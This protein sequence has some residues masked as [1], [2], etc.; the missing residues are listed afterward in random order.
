MGVPSTINNKPVN[1]GPTVRVT[2]GKATTEVPVGGPNAAANGLLRSQ[3]ANVREA[4]QI[5]PVAGSA[6]IR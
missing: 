2:R 5:A 3:A 6:L 4:G 1:S